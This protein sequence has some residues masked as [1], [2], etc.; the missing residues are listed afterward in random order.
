M[1]DIWT[2]GAYYPDPAERKLGPEELRE[3]LTTA[4]ARKDAATARAVFD[5]AFWHKTFFKPDWFHLYLAVDNKDREMVKLLTTYGATW[6]ANEA[7]VACVNLADKLDNLHGP[8]HAAGIRTDYTLKDLQTVD[9]TT[10]L[11]MNQRILIENKKNGH[12]VEHAERDY[13]HAVSRVLTQAALKGDIKLTKRILGFHAD[14][15]NP[16]GIDISDQFAEVLGSFLQSSSAR[17]LK[18]V[19][20]LLQADIKLQPIN[21]HKVS[22]LVL[23]NHY[24]LLSALEDRDLLPQNRTRLRSDL[25][26]SWSYLQSRIDLDGY[27]FQVSERHLKERQEK[28]IE[29]AN[30]LCNRYNDISAQEADRYIELH[31]RRSKQA[32]DA[33][34][35]MDQS[36]LNTDFFNKAAF[37]PAHLHALAED[38]PD[39]I[40]L[41]AT[42]NKMAQ[43]KVIDAR[44]LSHFLHKKRFDAVATA[45]KSGAL[46]PDG[47]ETEAI[48]R[49]LQNSLKKD[50]VTPDVIEC[51]THMRD[52]GAEFFRVR[53]GDYLGTSGPGLAKALL[54][55][56]IVK[57]RDISTPTIR[58]RCGEMMG[59]GSLL[60]PDIKDRHHAMREFLYQVTLEK[61]NPDKY[62]PLREK[63]GLSY[64]R[65]YLLEQLAS[66]RI[67]AANRNE[68]PAPPKRAQQQRYKK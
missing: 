49:Y 19:D 40:P 14:A 31:K 43:K 16:K 44:G 64:Q 17:A 24:D 28:H 7:K 57:A 55:L 6:T 58:K 61:S 8:L 20:T 26:Q 50:V 67:Q 18:F 3:V 56:D 60:N 21:L 12:N 52:N 10:L 15:K 13:N 5:H 53:R 36:L 48:M 39:N 38:T 11:S 4:V 22:S 35:H 47:I 46:V 9:A 27:I 25:L 51:L 30:V 33:I 32:P 41:A 45:L 42:F 54:D 68:R 23:P 65:R 29:A 1:Y 2:Y 66:I 63:A 59:I 62:K 37:T 34:T